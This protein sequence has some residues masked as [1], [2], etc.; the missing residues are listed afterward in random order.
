M[1]FFHADYLRAVQVYKS[2]ELLKLAGKYAVSLLVIQRPV[3]LVQLD[4]Y[5]LKLEPFKIQI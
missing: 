4:P 5:R 3:D 2:F 1:K